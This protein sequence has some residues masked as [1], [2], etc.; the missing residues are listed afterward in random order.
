MQII[1]EVSADLVDILMYMFVREKPGKTLCVAYP[2]V[3]TLQITLFVF[4]PSSNGNLSPL[5]SPP[6]LSTPLKL[7]FPLIF[8]SVVFLRHI[9][10]VQ[11]KWQKTMKMES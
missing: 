8:A 9:A 6:L 7:F 2:H 10:R 4:C 5:P 1:C 3:A 11:E